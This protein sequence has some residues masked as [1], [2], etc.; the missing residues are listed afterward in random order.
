VIVID[1]RWIK[2]DGKECP[3]P[4][5][6]RVDVIIR[7]KREMFTNLPAWKLGRLWDHARK[8]GDADNDITHYRLAQ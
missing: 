3:V 4:R 7:W 6:Q 8:P 2:H 1:P 5:D